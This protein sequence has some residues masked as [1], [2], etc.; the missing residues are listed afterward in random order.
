MLT[1]D[2][3]QAIE[4]IV[5]AKVNNTIKKELKPVNKSLKRIEKNLDGF[6][7]MFNREDM[8]LQKRVTRIEEH[9]K[10]EAPQN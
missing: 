9:L 7:K 2:D 3:L 5:E 10:L 8:Q 6:A 1:K 4:K